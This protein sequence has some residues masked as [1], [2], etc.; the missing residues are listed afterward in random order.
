MLPERSDASQMMVG[1]GQETLHTPWA[2]RAGKQVLWQSRGSPCRST[3]TQPTVS[4]TRLASSCWAAAAR[5]AHSEGSEGRPGGRPVRVPDAGPPDLTRVA[6]SGILTAGAPDTS[7]GSCCPAG[8]DARLRLGTGASGA[9]RRASRPAAVLPTGAAPDDG[10]V[11]LSCAT[12]P[13]AATDGGSAAGPNLSQCCPAA[14]NGGTSAECAAATMALY[15]CH[16]A[17]AAGVTLTCRKG[18]ATGNPYKSMRSTKH[19]GRIMQHSGIF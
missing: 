14:G 1:S 17:T 2:P 16:C 13:A 11:E 3:T 7:E 8:G 15:F 9:L 12:D 19:T 5:L 18:V 6:L 4:A 10:A